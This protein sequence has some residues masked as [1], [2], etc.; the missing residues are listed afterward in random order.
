MLERYTYLSV[1]EGEEGVDDTHDFNF[2]EA[3][4]DEVRASTLGT[5]CIC[6]GRSQR[7]QCR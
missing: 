6:D 1:F 7:C 4:I 2:L 3:L 5:H